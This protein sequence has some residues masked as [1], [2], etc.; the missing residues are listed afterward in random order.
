MEILIFLLIG[1]PLL[2]FIVS[3]IIPKEMEDA[4][5]MV[6][7]IT[8][9]IEL[10]LAIAFTIAWL[11]F[12]AHPINLHEM[13]VLKS[14]HYDFFL[15]FYADKLTIA[16]LL[17]GSLLT[18]LIGI[19]SRRYLHREGGYKRF[20]NVFL[21]FSFGFT[22]ILFSGNFETMFI[23]WE[24]L[25]VSSFLLIAFYRERYLPVKNAVKVF[26]IYRIGDV[27]L[28]LAMWLS[29]HLWGQ[30]IAFSEIGAVKSLHLALVN[31]SGEAVV[32]A[33]MIFI[34][35]AVKSAMFPFSSWLPRAMEGPTPSSAIFY[36]SLSVHIGAFLLIRTMP[37]W[38]DQDIVRYAFAGIGLLTAV[39][40]NFAAR[41]QSSIKS[42]VG[43][44][45]I[46]QLGIIFIE[47]AAGFETVA[48]IHITANAFYRTY[49][50]LISPSTVTYKIREQ[51]YHFVPSHKTLEDSWPKKIEYTLYSLS[52]REWNLDS[53]MY[54]LLWIPLKRFGNAL[55]FL[56]IKRAL[57]VVIPVFGI[58]LYLLASHATLPT[59]ALNVIPIV[60]AAAG[61]IMVLKSFT[62]RKSVLTSWFLIMF[63]QAFV[64]LAIAFNEH[65][66]VFEMLIFSS[67]IV[68]AG[69]V[70]YLSLRRMMRLEKQ[71]SLDQFQGHVYEH[72]KITLVF[73]LACLG[74]AGFPITP[75][76]VGEDLLFSH[77]GEK[78]YALA[79]L[80][81][82]SFIIDGIALIRIYSRVFLGPHHKTYHEVAKRSS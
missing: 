79:T 19:F 21:I 73:F 11:Y 38:Q 57:Y 20:F 75:T 62:E 48:I 65:L 63:N 78:Q 37:Y 68:V 30:N 72:P 23:G 12:G 54:R 61:L 25:G 24:I 41:V 33:C 81:S 46:A 69:M 27:G 58:G 71:V 28:I 9:G 51:F 4:I 8:T 77:I 5:A 76:F 17:F 1:L 29:H 74:V 13:S 53:L 7:K 40:S 50:L 49:Q 43:Y 59:W 80:A 22:L 64:V 36:G 26:S 60:L 3:T 42:Q 70:G 35:A 45:S 52:V 34:T 16:Y 55:G 66:S 10:L 39:M 56:S 2:G 18:F 47:I 31:H 82:V 67:G 14:G 44:A 6:V 32:I 15:D